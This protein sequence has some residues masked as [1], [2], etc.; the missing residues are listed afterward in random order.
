MLCH[1]LTTA[2]D[3]FTNIIINLCQYFSEGVGRPYHALLVLSPVLVKDI[4]A[5]LVASQP[6]S[7]SLISDVR[8][9]CN[10]PST[11]HSANMHNLIS[12]SKYD[13]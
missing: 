9:L 4:S 8:K 3:V 13:W 12:H 7:S 10:V 5:K 2:Y 1:T 6:V 11:W